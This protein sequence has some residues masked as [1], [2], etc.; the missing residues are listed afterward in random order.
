M[1]LIRLVAIAAFLCSLAPV[2]AQG[3]SLL[4]KLEG[5]LKSAVDN[6]APP[7][8]PAAA[9]AGGPGSGYLGMVAD[10]TAVPGQGVLV[11]SV[12]AGAPSELGG[13]KGGD[14]VTAIDDVPCRRLDDLDLALG[15]AGV[16]SKL[17]FTVNRGGASQNLTVTLGRKPIT[18]APG[19]EVPAEP[20]PAASTLPPLGTPP[21]PAPSDPLAFPP[22]TPTPAA[23]T[24]PIPPATP[25][26][27]AIDVPSPP[28]VTPPTI[29]P[30]AATPPAI[31]GVGEPTSGRASLGVTVV[32]LNDQTR[33]EFGVRPSVTSGAVIVGIR[34]GG[35]A[36]TAGLPIGG[37]IVRIDGTR[38]ASADDLIGAV[39][40]LRPGQEVELQVM[41]GERLTTKSVRLAPAATTA[42]VPPVP[43]E[44]AP[45]AI[46]GPDR[47]LLR[48][49]EN[50]VDSLG[51]GEPK[52]PIGSTI[53]DPSAI[54][55]LF[56]RVQTLEEKN[57]SLEERIKLLEAK[58][59]NTA[60][61]V[62]P[63]VLP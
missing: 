47:P 17:K 41:Q 20:P 53:L 52:T 3:Q 8:E 62:N 60:P 18:A 37:V 26:P 5:K 12:K 6:A 23:P 1:R 40:G 48:R 2:A 7:T 4:K 55:T 31:E 24:T 44:T 56:E 39:A 9:P 32:P 63:P 51:G 11:Q 15:K 49:F 16:G 29:T 19:S 34:R 27:P 59:G 54:K 25:T 57:A 38:V 36:E 21:A 50:L 43:S 30:P 45:P 28:A 13:L 42:L 22:I 58:L 61:A 46:G 33:A 10:E 14:I 35:P